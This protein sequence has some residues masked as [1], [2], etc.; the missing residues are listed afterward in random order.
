MFVAH[1]SLVSFTASSRPARSPPPLGVLGYIGSLC[2][3]V[4]FVNLGSLTQHRYFPPPRLA[5]VL[6]R[7]SATARSTPSRFARSGSLVILIV[8]AHGSLQT[9][10]DRRTRLA[11]DVRSVSPRGS[12]RTVVVPAESARSLQPMVNPRLALVLHCS[13]TRARSAH[14]VVR[15]FGLAQDLTVVSHLPARSY[16]PVFRRDRLAHRLQLFPS[17]GSLRPLSYSTC[18]ARSPCPVVLL[19]RLARRCRRLVTA[20]SLASHVVQLLWLAQLLQWSEFSARSRISTFEASGSLPHIVAPGPRLAR[21]FL[22]II[23]YRLAQHP[24]LFQQYGS[25]AAINVQARRLQ[26]TISSGAMRVPCARYA[27]A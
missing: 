21:S 6:R 14:P 18:P 4:I 2:C 27:L 17:L 19:L 9:V 24:R 10:V 13:S 22:P 23:T 11:R 15:V 16:G 26:P 3:L 8:R 5:R 7:F 1:G 25:L 20:G 12:L